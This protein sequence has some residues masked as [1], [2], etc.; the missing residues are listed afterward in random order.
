MRKRM[1]CCAVLICIAGISAVIAG[2]KESPVNADFAEVFAPYQ[3]VL[4]EFNSLH[5]T[6]YGIMTDEQLQMFNMSRQEY[7]EDMISAY[8][9][10]TLEEFKNGLE[11]A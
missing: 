3:E 11:I 6:T 2:A 5:G 1:T 7:E 4:E 10:M 9:C 8:S